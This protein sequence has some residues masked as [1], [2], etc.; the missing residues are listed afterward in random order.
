MT[1]WD[2]LTTKKV[3]VLVHLCIIWTLHV[4]VS[5]ILVHFQ[6]EFHLGRPTHLLLTSMYHWFLCFLSFT[7]CCT[8]TSLLINLKPEWAKWGW[9]LLR[10]FSSTLIN[11]DQTRARVIDDSL[12]KFGQVQ[13]WWE[14][15]RVGERTQEFQVKS[16]NN[17]RPQWYGLGLKQENELA[18]CVSLSY[19]CVPFALVVFTYPLIHEHGVKLNAIS[20]L[21]FCSFAILYKN[22][23]TGKVN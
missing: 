3:L 11:S 8:C 21:Q 13:I 16:L 15:T 5:I 19:Q 6:E 2:Q 9:Q 12:E 10:E 17:S 7:V 1:C 23:R 22:Y 20:C 4:R 14:S 18:A